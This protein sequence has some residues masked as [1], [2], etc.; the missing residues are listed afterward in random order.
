MEKTLLLLL[1]FVNIAVAETLQEQ[2]NDIKKQDIYKQISYQSADGEV[3]VVFDQLKIP[4]KS[5]SGYISKIKLCNAY[6]KTYKFDPNEIIVLEPNDLN[7][8]MFTQ[9]LNESIT[10]NGFLCHSPASL[11]C[12]SYVTIEKDLNSKV[13]HLDIYY[14]DLKNPTTLLKVVH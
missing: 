14:L 12:H 2:Y 8:R 7:Y 1:A 4:S 9:K 5:N 10:V 11:S 6:C 13:D 3:T